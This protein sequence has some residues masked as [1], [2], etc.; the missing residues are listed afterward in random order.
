MESSLLFPPFRLDVANEQLWREGRVIEL[1]PKTFAVLRYLAERPGRLVTKEEALDAVWPQT[2]VSESVLK[3]CIRE[4][5]KALADDAQNPQYIETVHRRGYRW[6]A[7][8][9]APVQSAR[10]RVPSLDAQ[11]SAL[12]AQHSL[13]VGRDP[14]LRQLQQYWEKAASGK[15]Q[16]LFATGEAGIG[17]TTLVEVFLSRFAANVNEDEESQKSKGKSQKSKLAVPRSLTPAPWLGRGQCIEHYGAGEAYLPILEALGRLCRG[18]E[19]EQLISLLRQHAP[20]WLV[21]LP[22]RL[23]AAELEALGP[24]RIIQKL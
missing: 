1:R 5:R 12:S 22:A 17:K 11:D 3:S 7:A 6:I 13:L 15:R 21:Q 19:G 2:V 4:L 9:A 16:L 20:T 10:S 8:G 18:T 24:I 14:D 23:D